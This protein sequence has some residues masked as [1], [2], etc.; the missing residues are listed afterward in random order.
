TANSSSSATNTLTVRP[1]SG[2]NTV[3]S[4]GITNPL[5]STSVIKLADADY[6][7]LDGSNDQTNSRNWTIR[8]PLTTTRSAVVWL[9]SNSTSGGI[10][11]CL[12]NT[13][14]NLN[15]IGSITNSTASSLCYGVLSSFNNTNLNSTCKNNNSNLIANNFITAVSHGITF[16]GDHAAGT[17]NS[18]NTITENVI[19]PEDLS[20]GDHIRRVG[21]SV[22]AQNQC[23]ISKNEIR[24]VG[25]LVNESYTAADR[26]GILI[27]NTEAWPNSSGSSCENS[28]ILSNII[29]DIFDE[30]AQ[31][32]VGLNYYGWTNPCNN[33]LANNVIYNIRSNANSSNQTIGMGITAGRND[34]VVFNSIHLFGDMD[35]AGTATM[36]GNVCGIRLNGSSTTN[37]MMANNVLNMDVSSNNNALLHYGLMFPSA[38]YSWGTGFS[39]YNDWY[40]NSSN[41]QLRFGA[42]QSS[43][44]AIVALSTVSDL[45]T[46]GT[47][48]TPAQE[49]HSIALDP[50]YINDENL[51]PSNSSPLI[52]AGVAGTGI[53]TDINT[54]TRSTIH[55]T[56]GAYEICIDYQD[57]DGDGYGN[58]AV[59][60]SGLCD[61]PTPGFVNVSGDCNDNNNQIHPG[62]VEI[63]NGLDDN[64]NGQIDEGLTFVTYYAD[65][66]GDGYGN[67]QNSIASCIQPSGYVSNSTDC[68]D[69]N[70]LIHPGAT[71]V[72]NGLDDDCNGQTDDGLPF[73]TYYADAD[74][75]GYG[76]VNVSVSTCDG[77]PSGYV[78][79]ATD[80]NDA[81]NSVHPN[82]TEIC[83][84]I[85][86]DC[87]G[88]TDDADPSISGQSI[89]Y[90]D[91]DGDG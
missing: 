30:K 59:S 74:G 67:L 48:F 55:P 71:E 7:I 11:G 65:T 50:L 44:S 84:G 46:W 70:A 19:G 36:T 64:C 82:A 3:L 66:D 63:C 25:V 12:N 40:I 81:S 18:N 68:N 26:F 9:A 58:P 88:L 4:S 8:N 20:N 27:E 43:A 69:A 21:I 52:G 32:A 42:F 13:I 34:K 76:N 78:S 91:T 56:I 80:C 72:C 29:H 86:D 75:D 15:I 47:S 60:Q 17:G 45:N 35:P 31:S 57:S 5:A 53:V 33:V 89:W 23:T 51:E 39:D 61:N 38:S 22:Y 24:N 14:K 85:D 16:F 1:A 6:I 37:F 73:V 62:S 54:K 90:A 77:A 41:T 28:S 49:V 2:V 83:N 10:L 87:D 79:D